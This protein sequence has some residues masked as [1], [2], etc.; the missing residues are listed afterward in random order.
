MSH[1]QTFIGWGDGCTETQRMHTAVR[2]ATSG[3]MT[4]ETEQAR[5]GIRQ[6]SLNGNA[7]GLHLKPTVVC[8]VVANFY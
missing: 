3:N 8:A 2:A 1:H 7:V 4:W 6:Y 5:E